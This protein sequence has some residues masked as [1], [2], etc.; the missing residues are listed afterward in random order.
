MAHLSS[1][2]KTIFSIIEKAIRAKPHHI[3][4]LLILTIA[5]VV[6]FGLYRFNFLLFHSAVGIFGVVVAGAILMFAWNARQFMATSYF[7]IIC[8]GYLA[9]SILDFLHMFTFYTD[10]TDM[11]GFFIVV[12]HY[13]KFLSVFLI[14]RAFIKTRILKPSESV[15]NALKQR[16]MDI[17]EKDATFRLLVEKIE[18]VFWITTVGLKKIIYISPGFE[19]IWKR[20]CAQLYADP[21]IFE[22]SIHPADRQRVMSAIMSVSKG[23]WD[24]AFRIFRPDGDQRWIRDHGYP[25][26]GGGGEILK[27][28]GMAHDITRLAR[29]ISPFKQGEFELQQ[30]KAMLHAVINVISDPM[31]MIDNQLHVVYS[32]RAAAKAYSLDTQAGN[33]HLSTRILSDESGQ[34]DTARVQA[35]M[36]GKK[37]ASF[38]LN[39]MGSNQLEKLYFYPIFDEASG[40]DGAVIRIVD[41][42]EAKGLERH[43]IHSEKMNALGM[44]AAGM[45]HE[46]NNPNSFISL[47]LPILRTYLDKMCIMMDSHPAAA[48]HRD[49]FGMDYPSFRREIFSLADNLSHGSSR[50]DNIISNLKMMTHPRQI[51]TQKKWVDLWDVIDKAVMLCRSEI[52]K[53]VKV[54]QVTPPPRAIEIKTDPEALEQV[55]I[56][57]LINASHAADKR[58]SWVRISALCNGGKINQAI[59]EVSDNGS[60]MTQDTMSR[61]F[62]P[63]F[64]T[65]GP[66]VGT[67]L[68]LSVSYNLICQLGGKILVESKIDNGARFR[69]VLPMESAA[70][71]GP[72]KLG[73]EKKMD[74]ES[75]VGMGNE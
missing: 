23:G 44:L 9:A 61:I 59:I 33:I 67:G 37:S 17:A 14:Y 62:D 50:I 41:I 69:V 66:G 12:G 60:G 1:I 49:W 8:M 73:F 20:S 22:N 72:P 16:E 53:R 34:G 65:K 64:T 5:L 74:A 52:R 15:V 4:Q 21:Q 47:N 70:S 11:Y 58:E 39:R 48:G 56:N 38:E 18:G 51:A 29:D 71:I 35:L 7:T 27:L 75:Y 32:N 55:I 2:Q 3:F 28:C 30:S 6:L 63:F 31:L 40:L 54:F 26:M 43:L 45:V 13:L 42:T 36:A 68:G 10:Y 19:K 57:L 46:I 24:V 25:V